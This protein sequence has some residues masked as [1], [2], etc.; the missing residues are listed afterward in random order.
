[1]FTIDELEALRHTD[2]AGDYWWADELAGLFTNLDRVG[3]EP[4]R[5]H[6]E[7][8]SDCDT[9]AGVRRR[10]G[11]VAVAHLLLHELKQEKSRNPQFDTKTYL[12]PW[13]HSRLMVVANTVLREMYDGSPAAG[14]RQDSLSCDIARPVAELSWEPIADGVGAHTPRGGWLLFKTPRRKRPWWELSFQPKSART[15]IFR[16]VFATESEAK[17]HAARQSAAAQNL[18]D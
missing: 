9:A 1:M 3:H 16:G 10:Y 8:I 12:D 6:F 13:Q 4:K 5:H 15:M 2:E 11:S 17:T 7:G 14:G 18:E